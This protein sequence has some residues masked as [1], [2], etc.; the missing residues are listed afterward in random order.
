MAT[1]HDKTQV[2]AIPAP[3]IIQGGKGRLYKDKSRKIKCVVQHPTDEPLLLGEVLKKCSRGPKLVGCKYSITPDLFCLRWES[4]GKLAKLTDKFSRTPS[5]LDIASICRLQPGVTTSKFHR[6]DA[7]TRQTHA[8]CFSIILAF[9]KTIDIVCTSAAQ[10]DRWF[11]G[12]RSL[13]DRLRATRSADPETA[14][15][16]QIW[17]HAD[18]NQDGMLS[19]SEVEKVT[20]SLNHATSAKGELRRMFTQVDLDGDGELDFNEYCALMTQLRHRPEL[21][22]LF[23]PSV[24]SQQYMTSSAFEAFLITNGHTTDDI[25]SILTLF[26]TEDMCSRLQFRQYINSTWNDWAN[27]HSMTLHHDMTLPLSQY[28]IASS[29]NTYLEGD[30]LQSH[31]SVYMYISA[32]L[33]NCRCVEIDCW[34]GDDGQP[35][36][37]HGHTLTTKI[38]FADVIWGIHVHAFESSPFPVILSLENHCSDAQQIVMADLMT[39]TF[40]DRLYID[41][42]TNDGSVLPSPHALQ[43]KIL[44]KGKQGQADDTTTGEYSDMDDDD[45][46][47]ADVVLHKISTKTKKQPPPTGTRRRSSKKSKVSPA[48]ARLCLFQGVH[49]RN[50][51][52]AATWPCNQMSSFSEGKT[53]KL[54]ADRKL[55][56]A[57]YNRTHLS[58]VYPSGLRVDSSNYN[59][60][61]G[62]GTGSQLVALNYQTADLPM[63]VNHG[64]FRQN[65]QC[66]YVLKP[67]SLLSQLGTFTRAIQAITVT[68]CSGQH[69]PKP[70]G[71]KK[72]EII[73]P[74]VVLDFVGDGVSSQ[75]KSPTIQ[76]NGL[77]PTWGFTATFDVG[78]E[79]ELHV[80]VLTVMDK[81][82]DRDDMIGFAALSLP[83]IRPGYRTVPLYASD[84]SRAG[85]YEFASLFCHFT[86][87]QAKDDDDVEEMDG[88]PKLPE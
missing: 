63:H 78:V 52:V 46:D 45:D 53:K 67:P 51:D 49:F 70:H 66:G 65:G 13:M 77:N 73:D 57:A 68:V 79:A 19:R 64:L 85:P 4:T 83:C 55:A 81:D 54:A 42:L 72:G 37:Y 12:L 29:H 31:S 48:L 27:P 17:I 34:D 2:D 22:A 39:Q 76:N 88:W 86:L 15:L 21:D 18:S 28:F 30:Q 84:G 35:V 82:L 47:S 87:Q 25:Q 60:V 14:F 50:F 9:G 69:L 1:V 36:V 62:W 71:D 32:L 38:L 58:R 16:Y 6:L 5:T 10:Y 20:R 56:F 40:G 33:R 3:M 44:L 74:Y 80:L 11:H 61:M 26:T 75:C 7:K 59:P 23:Q 24:K 41:D 8:L 43:Y